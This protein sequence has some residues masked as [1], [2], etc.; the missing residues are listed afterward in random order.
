MTETPAARRSP[1]RT[2]APV[3]VLA[4][5]LGLAWA[6]GLTDYLS[7]DALQRN[8]ARLA[9]Y[10]DAHPWLTL[11]GYIGVYIVVV[12]FSIPGALIMTLTGGMLFGGPG[13]GAAAITGATIGAT[14]IF[15]IARTSIG[16]ALRARA[17]PMV[18]R[19]IAGF[20]A[21]AASYLLTLRLIPG[22]PFFA[23][24]LAAGLVRMRL[25][26]YVIIT[27]AGIA[28]A[29]FIYASIGAS[30]VAIFARGGRPNLDIIFE[31]Q[32][33]GPLLGLAALSLL[34]VIYHRV[35]AARA[36]GAQA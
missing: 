27:L 6:T 7:L 22:V 19:I 15:L 28:P 21:N 23:V 17:G 14:I 11:L 9:A 34:P 8:Q 18:S 31:P 25:L 4:A 10:R 33:L 36:K 12:V 32:V 26:T 30:L 1:L 24:N 29:S 3:L 2:W 13:G 20:E 16:A 35:K 5:G